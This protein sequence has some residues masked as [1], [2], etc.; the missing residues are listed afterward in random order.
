MS[1]SSFEATLVRKIIERIKTVSD[2]T[3]YIGTGSNARVYG[4]HISTLR[5]CVFPAIT[6]HVMGDG[7]R[8]RD[9]AGET[10]ITMQIDL[11]FQNEG[12]NAYV[13]DDVMECFSAL[14]N[15]L[16]NNGHWDSSIGLNLFE[17]SLM[18]KGPQMFEADLKL[19]H[20]N[21]RFRARGTV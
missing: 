18:S 17:L 9:S 4:T 19:M 11:W 1:T 10:R 7:F 21:G 6:I 12:E 13:W 15:E 14:E 3:K 8:S 2:C 16:H 5:D 20:Y